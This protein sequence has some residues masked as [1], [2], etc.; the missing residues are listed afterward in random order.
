[1]NIA[2]CDD[3]EQFCEQIH[4]YISDYFKKYNIK[5]INIFVF[6]SG[7]EC[8]K[9]NEIFDIAFLD[10]EMKGLSGIHTGKEL[11]NRNPKLLFFII[12][13]HPQYLDEALHFHA[14]RYLPKPLEKN[15]LYI[16]LKD[17]LYVY[18]T[19]SK[20]IALET[21][22]EVLTIATSSIIMIETVKRKTVVY[23]CSGNYISIHPLKYWIDILDGLPFFQSHK[24]YIVNFGHI[25]RFDDSLIYLTD[26]LKAYLTQRKHSE[27]KKSFMMYIDT[28]I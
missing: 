28:T 5:D 22:D 16:N 10:V 17:A 7:E 24:S 27:F 14:F 2:I 1:M 23:T 19:L 6:N 11:S 20:K 13:S 26:N 9:C 8:L 15:R 12:T 18:N 3:N 4:T 21:K 25:E